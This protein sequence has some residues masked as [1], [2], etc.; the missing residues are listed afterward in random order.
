MIAPTSFRLKT[1]FGPPLP[2]LNLLNQFPAIF[3]NQGGF[4]RREKREEKKRE[5]EREKKEREREEKKRERERERVD[6]GRESDKR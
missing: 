2:I 3:L 6:E 4:E 5:R 1:N